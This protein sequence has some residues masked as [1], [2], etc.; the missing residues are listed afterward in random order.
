MAWKPPLAG[1]S[2]GQRRWHLSRKL[3]SAPESSSAKVFRAPPGHSRVTGRQVRRRLEESSWNAPTSDPLFTSG[4][5]LLLDTAA[6]SGPSHHSRSTPCPAGDVLAPRAIPWSG[7][8][9]WPLTR[10]WGAMVGSDEPRSWAVGVA[11]TAGIMG[12]VVTE[13]GTSFALLVS[14]PPGGH[15][16]RSPWR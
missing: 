11:E 14:G 3:S 15:R 5:A 10:L 1:L 12:R 6:R 2:A 8:P 16:R 9:S 7:P 4:R 13:V